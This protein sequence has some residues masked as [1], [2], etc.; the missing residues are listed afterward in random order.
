M[1]KLKKE[2]E[3]EEEKITI[4]IICFVISNLYNIVNRMREI[5]NKKK[6]S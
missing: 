5:E 2:E 4:Y 3:E 1:K 6:E